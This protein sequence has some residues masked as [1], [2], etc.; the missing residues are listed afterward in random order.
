MHK[1]PTD[2]RTSIVRLTADGKALFDRLAR[3]HQDWIDQMVGGLD[4][5]Q[6]ERLYVALGTLKISIAQFAARGKAR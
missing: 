2:R 3:A 1:L 5:T 6:R 4:Y